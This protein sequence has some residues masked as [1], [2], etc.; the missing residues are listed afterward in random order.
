MAGLHVGDFT[1]GDLTIVKMSRIGAVQKPSGGGAYAELERLAEE[2]MFERRRIR[3]EARRLG[4]MIDDLVSDEVRLSSLLSAMRLREDER[5]VL[6]TYFTEESRRE[7]EE[8]LE[9][10]YGVRNARR[11]IDQAL[12]K[13]G[14]LGKKAG[15]GDKRR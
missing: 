2:F 15:D 1:Y 8:S 9:E 14:G 5:L 12:Q 11:A 10:S 6:H 4:R 7:A 3:E 13:A